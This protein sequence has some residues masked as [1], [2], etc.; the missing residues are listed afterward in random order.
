[1]NFRLYSLIND[2]KNKDFILV[3]E[4]GR[5]LG[6]FFTFLRIKKFVFSIFHFNLL[7]WVFF[8]A[9]FRVKYFYSF[10]RLFFY[11][12]KGHS[13]RPQGRLGP[14]PYMLYGP[15]WIH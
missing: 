14:T 3:S 9:I 2:P 7:R 11:S 10:N 13:W 15:L 8:W 6:S 1:M 5:F 4:F 12:G